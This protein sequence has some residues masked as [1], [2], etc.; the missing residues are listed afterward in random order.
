MA[1]ILRKIYNKTQPAKHLSPKREA[2]TKNVT[3]PWPHD[4]EMQ[5]LT[6]SWWII[7]GTTSME[8]N[9]ALSKLN[10]HILLRILPTDTPA[11]LSNNLHTDLFAAALF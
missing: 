1:F 9:L 11:H 2:K 4:R 7:T 3:T 8:Q 10:S 6:H 5:M